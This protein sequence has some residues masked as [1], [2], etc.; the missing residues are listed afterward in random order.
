MKIDFPIVIKEV[1][2]L[3][4]LNKE[5]FHVKAMAKSALSAYKNDEDYMVDTFGRLFFDCA[6]RDLKKII[7]DTE[8]DIKDSE[9]RIQ[10]VLN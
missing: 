8:S 2:K 1:E 4:D 5:A 10:T 9:I 7:K 3:Q 6:V